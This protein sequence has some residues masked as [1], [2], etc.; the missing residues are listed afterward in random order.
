LLTQRITHENSISE[1]AEFDGQGKIDNKE[2]VDNFNK[3]TNGGAKRG[4]KT[5]LKKDQ[6][7]IGGGLGVGNSRQNG[8]K[9]SILKSKKDLS[10]ELMQSDSA[11]IFEQTDASNM[12]TFF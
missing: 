6:I 12:Q 2:N 5:C 11:D 3:K 1:S 7:S 9:L 10:L 8:M 4:L